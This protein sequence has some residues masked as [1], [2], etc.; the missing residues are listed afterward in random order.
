[1][2]VGQLCG[3]REPLG[4]TSEGRILQIGAKV[5]YGDAPFCFPCKCPEAS[6][7]AVGSVHDWKMIVTVVYVRAES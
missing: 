4:E 3:L 1:M 2:V 7:Y 6:D 5:I